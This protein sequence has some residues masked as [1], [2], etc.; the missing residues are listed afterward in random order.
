[1]MSGARGVTTTFRSMPQ[2]NPAGKDVPKNVLQD[3]LDQKMSITDMAQHL[4]ISRPTVY[5]LLRKHG[6]ESAFKYA[7]ND[8]L[9]QVMRI[10]VDECPAALTNPVLMQE[11]LR[12]TG[13][14]VVDNYG[15]SISE[16]RMQTCLLKLQSEKGVLGSPHL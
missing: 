4:K 9:I 12:Q 8:Q 6:L 16:K 7:T 11:R 15:Y 2:R 3:L 1:M 5:K 14:Q 10:I 13:N